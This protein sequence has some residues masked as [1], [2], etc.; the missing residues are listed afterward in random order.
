MLKIVKNTFIAVAVIMLTVS[1]A[2]MNNFADIFSSDEP[3]NAEVPP[4]MVS[5]GALM[6]GGESMMPMRYIHVISAADLDSPFYTIIGTVEG[7][8][9]VN[10][11]NPEDG[12]THSYGRLLSDETTGVDGVAMEGTA[13]YDVSLSNAVAELID[14]AWDKGA[15]FVVF[16]AYTVRFTDDRY[17][18]TTIR[19]IAVKMN[20]AD[21]E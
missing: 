20:A 15:S 1:C 2:S 18:E 4:M 19:A 8:G 16:P 14:A 3:E 10:A 11:D 9:R 12:D 13:A 6:P 5:S 7:H 21:A 17:I